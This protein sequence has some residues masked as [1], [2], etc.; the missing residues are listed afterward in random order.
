M[1]E[2]KRLLT[3]YRPTGRLHVGHYEGNLKNMIKFQD[4][5]NC[6]FFV[7]DWHAMT[8]KYKDPAKL[9]EDINEM[10]ADWLAIGLD[11]EKCTIYKQSD[12][13]EVAELH[14]YLS[15]IT[16][17]GWLE[18]NPTYKE[19]LKELGAKLVY[20]YGFLGYPVLQAADILIMHSSFVPVGE[21]QLPH[22]ELSREIARRFNYY[23]GDY[24]TEPQA[25]LSETPRVSGTDGRKMSKSYGNT[26]DLADSSEVIKKKVAK[27]VTDTTR[28]HPTDPGHPE[29]CSVRYIHKIFVS[30][31]AIL[32]I[33]EKCRTATMTCVE[34]KKLLSKT[35]ADFLADFRKKREEIAKK[36]GYVQEVLAE[37]LKK[38]KPIAEETLH[39]VRKRMNIE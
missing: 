14:L 25:V 26:I 24:L 15:M 5:Y 39:E 1:I 37:G 16:P 33:D 3:G 9:Q 30:E 6:F 11:P 8:T 21:D 7:A 17:L 31:P 4:E 20:T 2:K 28:I 34:C 27:M 23:Y 12:L 36:P 32:E 35:I 18:R 19:Q 22:L 38:A 10:V 13:P 29:G